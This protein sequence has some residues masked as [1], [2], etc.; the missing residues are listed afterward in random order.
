MFVCNGGRRIAKGS[1]N[2]AGLATTAVLA[3][4]FTIVA[5]RWGTKAVG[6]VLPRVS[7][8]LRSAEGQFSVAM[9]FLFALSLAA[10]Y[11]GV[12]A[13]VGAFLAGMALADTVEQRVRDLA[14]GVTE[15]LVPFFLAGIGVQLD[16]KL[17]ANKLN[18]FFV[19]TADFFE[20]FEVY[21]VQ[22]V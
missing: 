3:I 10:M 6:H 12:A 16:W 20:G 18:L 4:G 7:A 17:L 13:I 8:S 21:I 9:V 2:I 1:V 15:L 11:A 5:A 19:P 14:H 22:Q